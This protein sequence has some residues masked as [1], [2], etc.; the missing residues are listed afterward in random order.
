ML[1]AFAGEDDPGRL[2]VVASAPAKLTLTLRIIGTR[3][4]GYHLLDSEMVTVDLADTL[5]FSA[6]DGLEVVYAGGER[7]GGPGYVPTGADNLVSRALSLLGRRA[8]V[9]LEKRIP[10]GG[11]LGGG[12]ADAAAVLR[13]AGCRDTALASTLGA[14]VPF[15]LVGG[16][17]RVTGAGEVV[18][19]LP[20]DEV[21]GRAYTLAIPPF[22]VDTA[23][24]YEQWD[25]MGGPPAPAGSVNDLELA[26]LA[27]E[28][29]L[30]AW[31]DALAEVAGSHPALAGSGATWFVAGEH[32]G[33]GRV[34]VRVVGHRL[35][36]PKA[37]QVKYP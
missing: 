11:G 34:V 25:R 10:A 8:H 31:R 32:P 21:A 20:F 12:S 22:G 5:R 1:N 36:T 24:V 4:D 18:T 7:P 27:V 14:D 37:P 6:G 23:A 35:Q 30:A 17:A 26:A 28:P 9:R 2:V 13:W 3:P 16:R 15:C 19:P 33:E 29:R